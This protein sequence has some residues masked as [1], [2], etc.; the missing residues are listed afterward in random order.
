MNGKASFK[1]GYKMCY[2]DLDKRVKK[3]RVCSHFPAAFRWKEEDSP[4]IAWGLVGTSGAGET[5]KSRFGWA[6]QMRSSWKLRSTAFESG[7][8]KFERG[9]GA[10]CWINELWVDWE[11]QQLEY[12]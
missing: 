4:Q 2:Y 12:A 7:R 10:S 8:P 9:D 6:V 3:V 1:N 5:K 11:R